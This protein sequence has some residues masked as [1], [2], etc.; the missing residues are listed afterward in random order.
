MRKLALFLALLVS[1]PAFGDEAVRIYFDGM[2]QAGTANPLP[3]AVGAGTALIGKVGI[4]QATANAN[5]VV[6]K[7]GSVTAATLQAGSAIVGK[8][9][10]DQ[11]TPGTT[12]GVQVNAALPA[13][14]NTIG[15]VNIAQKTYLFATGT[16]ATAGD[17]PLVAAPGAGNRLVVCKVQIQLEAAVATTAILA[18]NW[19]VAFGAQYDAL[20]LD[21][22]M[23]Q[24]MVLGENT[25]L[26]LNLSGANTVG[27][28]V[29]YRIEAL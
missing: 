5:Q 4:D 22:P 27:Y 13:G 25:A 9:G 29:Q 26:N 3:T 15:S 20:N 16:T 11:T 17:Q 1:V 2:T 8:V 10:I 14:T 23:G 28:S 12:N 6:T 19:R 7:T 24:E 18:S 21:F